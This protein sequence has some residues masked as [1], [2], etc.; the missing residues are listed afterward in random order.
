MTIDKI[1][2]DTQTINYCKKIALQMSSINESITMVKQIPLCIQVIN[3]IAC[4]QKMQEIVKIKA[5]ALMSCILYSN[6][7]SNTCTVSNIL[8]LLKNSIVSDRTKKFISKYM[9]LLED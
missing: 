9:Y 8:S 5:I 2:S 3:M 6:K 4:D 1:I 7:L